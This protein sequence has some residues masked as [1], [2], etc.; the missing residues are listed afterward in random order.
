MS[1]DYRLGDGAWPTNLVDCK[2]AVRFLRAHAAQYHLDPNR[3]AVAGGSAGG[4]LAL[5]V[6]LTGDQDHLEPSGSATPYPGVSSAV[7]CVINM[8]GVT[9]LQ[10]RRQTNSI[11]QP[12]ATQREFEARWRV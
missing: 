7:R 4:H 12:T 1:I 5:M 9:N 8:Y 3:I 2:N 11:G 10:T 6:A